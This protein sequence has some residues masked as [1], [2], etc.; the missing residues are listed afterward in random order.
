MRNEVVLIAKLHNFAA[1]SAVVL[2]ASLLYTAPASAANPELVTNGTLEGGT[3]GGV[4]SCFTRYEWGTRTAT[5]SL[6]GAAHSGSYAYQ[7]K[8]TAR[9]SGDIKLMQSE[10]A[11]C[12]PKVSAGH[13]YRTSVWYKSTTTG[14]SVTVFKHTAAGWA[15]WT[16]LKKPAA[17]SV[18]TNT[19]NNTPAVPAGVDQISFGV[20]ISAVGTL[21]TDDYSVTD[22]AAA[23]GGC[24]G[25]C[26][27]GQW[28]LLP[29]NN[30]VK[31]VH[32]ILLY[33]GKVL[34][35]A[36]SG[37][38]TPDFQAGTF[39]STLF[40]P[41]ANSFTDVPTPVDLFCSGHAQL[42]NGNILI[43]GGTKA[44][45]DPV[46]DVA[47]T[48]L[49]T[50]YIFN[51]AT[52]SYQRTNDMNDGHWYPSSTEM[53][54]GDVVTLGGMD[55][56]GDGSV[57]TEYWSNAAGAWLPPANVKQTYSWWGMYP[58]MILTADGKLFYTGSH[59][60]GPSL[61]GSGASLYDYQAGTITDIPGLREKDL[62][63][64]SAALMLPP[65]QNQRVMIMGGGDVNN[66]LTAGNTTDII[67][68]NR[69]DPAYTPG[70]NLLPGTSDDEGMETGNMGKGY[71]SAV[72]LP[73][74]KVF[75]TGGS[76]H[77]RAD[78]VHEASLYDPVANT[79]T[80]LPVDP[81]GR[82]YHNE[83]ILLADGRVLSVGGNPGD[84]SFEMRMSVYSPGYLFST[85]RPTIGAV[86]ATWRYGSTQA[87]PFT[88][89]NGVKSIQL[90]KP[91]AVT[92][93]SDS[94]ARSVNVPFT[95]N[96]NTATGTVTANPNIAPPGYYALSILD[97]NGVP[98]IAKW[99]KVAP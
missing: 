89:G 56:R 71:V 82:G 88:S 15:Y 23:G 98:S 44:Y 9:T 55:T 90:I 83:A 36:G 64:Q 91:A 63:D 62:R 48:G 27:T 77:D 73:N 75:E 43:M 18:W 42:A 5:S 13:V 14:I 45:P 16:D 6:V 39:K 17:A 84:G 1:L 95:L 60:F 28:N 74:G 99:V 87:I 8:V 68:L 35:M 58:T 2:V 96:G 22:T 33:T 40:D 61:P 46:G 81:V 69:A 41:V 92:H 47:F 78:N 53:G 70:P 30:H 7:T 85:A 20:S 54:N 59:T 37:N 11:A 29:F 26:L 52:S 65:A 34:L 24:T 66:N 72:I 38:Y 4:P 10:T 12:A 31:S 86:A 57:Q 3:V 19:V 32:A 25:L 49:T 67:D 80:A 21:V 76:L 94:N 97:N 93:S 79:F 51:V 50:S